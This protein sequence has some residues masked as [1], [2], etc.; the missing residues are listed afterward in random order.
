[1]FISSSLSS[2]FFTHTFDNSLALLTE[3]IG[4]MGYCSILAYSS[5]IFVPT[6]SSFFFTHNL[7][8]SY[9][10]ASA[11]YILVV[12][13]IARTLVKRICPSR[14]ALRAMPISK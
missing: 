5:Y 10:F 8:T 12:S 7:Y 9:I 13:V 6:L 3:Y 2:P 4:Y 11:G 1:M 14:F